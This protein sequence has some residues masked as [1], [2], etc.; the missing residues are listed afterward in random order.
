MTLE[1]HRAAVLLVGSQVHASAQ[2]NIRLLRRQL[3]R[4]ELQVPDEAWDSDDSYKVPA[5]S[6]PPE[7]SPTLHCCRLPLTPENATA[8]K[9]ARDTPVQRLC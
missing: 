7:S 3:F 9:R 8:R 4:R 1:R 2:W 6:M 5:T